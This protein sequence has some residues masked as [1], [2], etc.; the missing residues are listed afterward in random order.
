MK[1]QEL[2]NLIREEVKKVVAEAAPIKLKLGEKYQVYDPGMD[3]WNDE[4]EYLGFDTNSGEYM[5]RAYD[6][7]VDYFHFVGITKTDLPNSVKPSNM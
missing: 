2:K 3:D 5:F 6:S 7:P 4:Y 1:V